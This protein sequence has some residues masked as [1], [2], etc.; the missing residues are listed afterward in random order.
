MK[1]ILLLSNG[2]GEDLNASVI[3]SAIREINPH[4][5]LSGFPIVGEGKSYQN[6]N[7]EIVAPIHSMPSGGMFYLKPVNLIKDIFSGLISLTIKQFIKLNKIKKDYDLIVAVGDIVPVLFAYLTKRNF[8]ILFVAYS[9]YYNGNTKLSFIERQMLKSPFCLG[10]LTKDHLTAKDIKKAG[11]DKVFCYGY[12]IMDTLNYQK[13]ILPLTK[14]KK[15][16]ALLPGSRLPEAINNFKLQLKVC[17]KVFLKS[18]QLWEFYGALVPSISN[19]YLVNICDEMGWEFLPNQEG[20]NILQ[21]KSGKNWLRVRTYTNAFADILLN[22]DVVLGMAGTAV[23]Q[24]VGLGK[25]IVQ[26][27][28]EGPQFTYRFADAQMRLLGLNVRTIAPHP[29]REKVFE[30]AAQEIVTVVEDQDYLERCIKN[31]RERVGTAGS[32]RAIALHVLKEL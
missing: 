21:K 7:I 10:I 1:K 18:P 29:N 24:A 19:Q 12:P 20:G 13:N 25:P 28:G 17:E 27:I 8:F 16:M 31:G 3:A 5:H 30:E 6:K 2:H 22:C 15:M 14:D 11:F 26:I 23:E 9:S 4:I 32:S